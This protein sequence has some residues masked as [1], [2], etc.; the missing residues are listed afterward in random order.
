MFV[1]SNRLAGSSLKLLVLFRFLIYFQLLYLSVWGR[2]I[3]PVEYLT[4]EDIRALYNPAGLFRLFSIPFPGPFIYQLLS[5]TYQLLLLLCMFGIG[6]RLTSVLA[7]LAGLYVVSFPYQFGFQPHYLSPHLVVLALFCFM[8]IP[9][10]WAYWRSPQ[11]RNSAA[12]EFSIYINC[13]KLVWISIFFMAGI[14]KLKQSGLEYFFSERHL[15][16][17]ILSRAY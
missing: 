6:N 16:S 13:F 10:L 2:Q 3:F 9:S 11:V 5:N 17:I 7:L 14:E 15:G 4:V 8:K 12:E 1:N